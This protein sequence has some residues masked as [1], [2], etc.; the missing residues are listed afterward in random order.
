[1]RSGSTDSYG[2]RAA[3]VPGRSVEDVKIFVKAF[4]AEKGVQ[5]KRKAW[6]NAMQSEH[7]KRMVIARRNK[8]HWKRGT[9]RRVKRAKHADGS[10]R[11]LRARSRTT[12]EPRGKGANR[13]DDG[14]PPVE[15]VWDAV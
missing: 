8:C 12:V 9:E 3:T 2:K 13:Q 5:A 10:P 7:V 6:H 15:Q 4:L 1:M 14:G 11:T